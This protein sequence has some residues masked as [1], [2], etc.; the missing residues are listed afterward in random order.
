MS[1][2]AGRLVAAF[3]FGAVGFGIGLLASLRLTRSDGGLYWAAAVAMSGFAG[4]TG[5]GLGRAEGT[6][7]KLGIV[8]GIAGGVL[9]WVL[10]TASASWPITATLTTL[11][12]VG[13]ATFRPDPPA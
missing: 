13:L 1:G 6:P 2:R 9:G 12:I 4:G 10:D 3:V 5:A 11:L 7:F 8:G